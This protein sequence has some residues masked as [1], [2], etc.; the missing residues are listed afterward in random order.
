MYA[1]KKSMCAEIIYLI[2]NLLTVLVYSIRIILLHLWKE[3]QYIEWLILACLGFIVVCVPDV[4]IQ[5]WNVIKTM[6]EDELSAY[7]IAF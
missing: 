4:I 3:I 5:E 1:E 2:E 6:D 7:E